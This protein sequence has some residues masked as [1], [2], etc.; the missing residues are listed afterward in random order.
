TKLRNRAALKKTQDEFELEQ[1]RARAKRE[2]NPAAQTENLRKLG[3][4]YIRIDN[5]LNQRVQKTTAY[6]AL[7]AAI[8]NYRRALADDGSLTNGLLAAHKE[9]F[10]DDDDADAM[11]AAMN[12][13]ALVAGTTNR[14][15]GLL[16]EVGRRALEM[17]GRGNE[18][19]R[20]YRQ[21]KT[22]DERRQFL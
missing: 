21:L 6:A 11:A 5:D 17:A 13:K 10:N 7:K 14:L 22:D 16:L 15:D 19:R 2:T 12:L 18:T 8:D 20:T 1:M 4:Y 9:E 3:D